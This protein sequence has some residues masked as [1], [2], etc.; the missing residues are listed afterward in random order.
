ME[1]CMQIQCPN[2]KQQYNVEI[3]LVGERV[4]CVCGY[5]WV[6]RETM[7]FIVPAK[8][9]NAHMREKSLFDYDCFDDAHS[10]FQE[11]HA[12]IGQQYAEYKEIAR[13]RRDKPIDVAYEK[14]KTIC[15]SDNPVP[16]V[17]KEFF[18]LCR[19]KNI[20]DKNA[21]KYQAVIDRINLMFELDKKQ[22]DVIW[23]S[24]AKYNGVKRSVIDEHYSKITITDRKT[25]AKCKELL[26][27]N[28]ET[29]NA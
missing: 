2:C 6:L 18:K 21:K 20:A 15:A 3:S 16:G 28:P 29:A 5:K 24:V 22:R 25:F 4:E 13:C 7:P 23:L 27:I 19:K 17:Y 10:A 12:I 11:A 14:A 9:L 1:E 8:D 26:R